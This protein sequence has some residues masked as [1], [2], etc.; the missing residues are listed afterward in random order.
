[1]G[2]KWAKK[3]EVSLLQGAG[4]YGFAWFEQHTGDSYDWQDAPRGRSKDA[5]KSK[6][7]RLFQSGI[8]RGSYTLRQII[9]TTGYGKKQI[10]RAMQALGQKWKRTSSDGSYL[11][12]EEQLEEILNW[13]RNDYWCKKHGL[14]NCLW[15]T[16][17]K[18]PHMSHGLCQRCFPCYEKRLFRAGLPINPQKLMGVLQ[19]WEKTNLRF[20]FQE[21]F[22]NLNRGR[23]IPRL[24]F[25]AI[26]KLLQ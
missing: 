25:D 2:K 17:E 3:H 20:D 26:L 11:I 15:C 8:G 22:K 10:R 23:A 16:T 5:V 24:E 9:E 6:A 21:V 4:V 1:V 14:Y 19:S 7:R 18:R 13:L 12:Y